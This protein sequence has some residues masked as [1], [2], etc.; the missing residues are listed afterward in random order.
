M[1]YSTTS[2]G[3]RQP[4]DSIWQQ[5][6]PQLRQ[7]PDKWLDAA[8]LTVNGNGAYTVTAK[9]D[10]VRQWLERNRKLIEAALGQPVTFVVAE[11]EP[12]GES[13]PEP[14][15]QYEATYH[16]PRNEIIQPNKVEVH[17]Q[18]FRNHWRPLLGPLLSELVRELRQQCYHGKGEDTTPRPTTDTTYADLAAALGV[19]EPTI[20][21]ALKRDKDGHFQNELL[22]EFIKGMKPVKVRIQG[23]IRT[24]GTR[25]TIWMDEELTPADKAIHTEGSK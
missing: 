13:E 9:T 21:R 18:Y 8:A 15:P 7:I 20:K 25:F 3:A 12:V 4:L 2:D 24:I 16:D 6:R 5:A 17:T 11:P 23:Q 1:D 10:T 14:G 19:S 22:H